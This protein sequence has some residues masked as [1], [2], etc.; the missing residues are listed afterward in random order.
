LTIVN[1]P[2]RTWYLFQFKHKY[3]YSLSLETK[4]LYT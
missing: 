1:E 4:H 2:N 3:I